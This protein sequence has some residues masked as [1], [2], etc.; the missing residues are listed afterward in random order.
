[1]EQRKSKWRFCVSW[2]SLKAGYRFRA[3]AARGNVLCFAAQSRYHVAAPELD[4]C[5]AKSERFFIPRQRDFSV[6][7][8]FSWDGLG[9]EEQRRS[10]AARG[11]RAS[12]LDT[13]TLNKQRVCCARQRAATW[14]RLCE[15]KQRTLPCAAAARN[16]YTALRTSEMGVAKANLG[17]CELSNEYKWTAACLPLPFSWW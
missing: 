2:N 5:R 15:A 7:C 13:N 6:L 3:A 14:Y 9:S 16:R 17:D 1:M 10:T 11:C 8:S 12:M 4:V